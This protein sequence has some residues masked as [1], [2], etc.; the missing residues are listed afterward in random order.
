[1]EILPNIP[2]CLNSDCLSRYECYRFRG[3]P[4]PRKQR[5]SEFKPEKGRD[6][7][8]SFMALYKVNKGDV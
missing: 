7:C 8:D 5:Y 6:R 1:M 4:I 2:L 3:T